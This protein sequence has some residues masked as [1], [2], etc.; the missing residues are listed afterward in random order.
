MYKLLLAVAASI[1]MIA[2]ESM[3]TS[4]GL[5]WMLAVPV[6]W[7]FATSNEEGRAV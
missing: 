4:R 5:D 2:E 1:R 7:Q 6:E 3:S